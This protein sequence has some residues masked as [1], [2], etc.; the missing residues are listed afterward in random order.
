MT[1]KVFVDGHAG[2]IGLRIRQLLAD[3]V[4]LSILQ[5]PE[6]FRKDPA[7]RAEHLNACDVAI[8]CLP[9]AASRE[10]VGLLDNEQVRVIDGSTAFRVEDQWVYGLPEICGGQRD[11]IATARRVSNPGCWPTGVS[12]LTRPLI[13]AGLF[14]RDIALSIHGVSGYSGAGKA[15]IERWQSEASGLVNLPYEAPYALEQTHKHIPEMQVYGG[16]SVA[17]YFRPAVGSFERGMRIQIPLHAS[18]LPADTSA[19]R[20]IDAYRERYA[21]EAFISVVQKDKARVADEFSLDPQACNG[22]NVVQLRVIEHPEGH[23]VLIAV[24]DN[25]GKG[26]SGAAVQSLNLMLGLHES[27][28]L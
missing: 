3:R 28:G 15:A 27:T 18:Q 22:T 11:A 4:D 2:T 16:L 12:L 25:L 26:A 13:D 24:L 19:E 21:D 8:L 9:D 1:A 20:I 23:L 6:K 17:P 10:A 7:A 5:I 14:P